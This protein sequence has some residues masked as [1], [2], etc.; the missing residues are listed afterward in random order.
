MDGLPALRVAQKAMVQQ[1]IE[2]LKKMVGPLAPK[3]YQNDNR[4]SLEH[5]ILVALATAIITAFV[6][7]FG[8]DTARAVAVRLPA[9]ASRFIHVP[10]RT[11]A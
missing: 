6:M 11:Q 5:L 1:G 4:F 10:L 2:P 3:Q 7:R 9:D 8:F